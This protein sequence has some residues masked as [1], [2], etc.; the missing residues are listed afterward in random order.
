M[1][2]RHSLY[3]LLHSTEVFGG[4][5]RT[6]GGML[7]TFGKIQRMC[8]LLVE[9]LQSIFEHRISKVRL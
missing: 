6:K 4:T 3:A 8:A 5:G 9:V 1:K 2:R 7:G